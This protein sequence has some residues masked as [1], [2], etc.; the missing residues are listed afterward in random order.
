VEAGARVLDLGCGLGDF[1][2]TLAEHGANAIGCDVAAEA[3]RR[4]RERHPGAD[5]VLSADSLPF[6]DRSVDV[7]WAGEVL[8]HVQDVLGLLAEVH[9]VLAGDGRLLVSTPDHAPLRR[10]HLGLSRRAFESNFDPRSDHVRFF[11]SNT[12]RETL[13]VSRFGALE[14]TSTRGVLFAEARP[15]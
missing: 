2:A 15:I 10:L 11:T 3:L 14:L 4:A 12:L 8:E 7:V 9:R 1:T 13:A 6:E 5:F